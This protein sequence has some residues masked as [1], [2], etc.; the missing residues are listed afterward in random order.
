[1]GKTKR[2]SVHFFILSLLLLSQIAIVSPA[3]ASFDFTSFTFT[4]C[5]QTG[6]TGPTQVACRS[7][8][9][10]TWDENDLY[11]SVSGG[12]QIWTVPYTGSY[13]INA[14]GA[15]GSAGNGGTAPGGAGARVQGNFS[16]NQGDKIRILVGQMGINNATNI[17]DGASGSGG[18]GT[19]VISGTSG[20]LDSQ[21]LLI[22]AGG[23]G[24]NDPR[25]QQSNSPGIGGLHTSSGTGDGENSGGSYRGTTNGTQQ[26]GGSFQAGA[27]GGT[28]SRG[29]STGNGGFGGGGA[30]DDARTGGGGWLGGTSSVGAYSKNN[31]ANQ[32]GTSAT[33]SG[34]GSV[35][36][37]SLGPSVVTFNSSTSLTNSSSVTFN[38]VFSQSVT[39]LANNDFTLSGTGSSTCTVSTSGSG[40]SYIITLTNCSAGTVALALSANSVSNGSSQTGPASVTNSG[41]ITIDRTAPTISTLTPPANATYKPVDT[42]TFTIAFSESMT[43]TGTPRLT[44]TVGAATRYANFVSL[45]DSRTALF[46][47]T[48]AAS[49]SEFDIDGISVANSID[50]NGGAI[51]DLAT[52]AL[53]SL[54]FS[55]LNTSSILVA[56][57][58]AAPII[59]SVTAGS[60]VVDVYFTP[61]ATYGSA[62]TN[63]QISTNNGGLWTVRSPIATTSPIRISSLLN[64]TPYQVRIRAVSPVG[65]SESSTATSV[66][67]NAVVVG[68]GSNITTTFGTAASSTAFTASG[69]LGSYAYTLSSS[70][71]GLSISSG[72][73]TA[74]N[75]VQAGTYN[76]NVIGTDSNSAFGTRALVVTVNKARQDT[77][78]VTSAAGSFNGVGSRLA[79]MF[80]GGSDT[81]T[82]TYAI[83]I[84]GT[85][86]GCSIDGTTLV[87]NSTGTCL[88]TVSKAATNNFLI[89]TSENA[90]ITFS[91]FISYQPVQTQSVPTQIPLNG[92]NFLDLTEQLTVPAITGIFT[93]GSTYEINGA[94]FTG[95]VRVIIGGM[96]ATINSSTA[97]KIVISNSGVMPGPIFIECSD[98]RMGPSPFYFF[99]P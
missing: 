27:Q 29:G 51:T 52:N 73:V 25:Y 83:A 75:T 93:V 80:S 35:T 57:P 95:V 68:G 59:D 30:T 86:T 40:T 44:L 24:S 36:I 2:N 54:I 77:L 21:V 9:S 22:A 60:T 98:G 96:D 88:V 90:T 20:T 5:N 18:G 71:S 81:G 56:Q 79:L 66:T 37:T 8:Y 17:S 6:R 74:A 46:R 61:G 72:V 16:L 63:Y 50:L 19:F 48:V 78:T 4:S 45:T 62:I 84:G 15:A 70:V 28:Y 97:T 47:Y 99:V 38:L 14:F 10:T 26:N 33:N 55:A 89:A 49:T 42:P 12:I 92:Q 64:G 1:M 34:A 91:Q 65:V 39:G 76:L 94:G 67:P 43:V 53:A 85:A 69:G 7:A 41:S 23:G 58:P 11:F 87:V 3:A 32:L 13:Q 31:G 82:A